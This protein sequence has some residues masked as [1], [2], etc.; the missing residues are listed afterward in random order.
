MRKSLGQGELELLR[1]LSDQGPM[2]V[3]EAA[4]RYGAEAGLARTTVLTMMERLREK[5]H[6]SRRKEG[7]VW[8]YEAVQEK[9][10][11]L[12]GVVEGFVRKALGGS[13]SPFVA[14]LAQKDDLKPE[15]VEELRALVERL[16]GER[17]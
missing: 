12:Q 14:Y 8:V 6:L 13:V 15:E 5:G 16:E 3:R 1:F 9:S 11:L 17:P 10:A 7:G 2:G 4:D